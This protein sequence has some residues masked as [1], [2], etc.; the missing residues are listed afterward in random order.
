MSISEVRGR[1]V[2]D[3]EVRPW[4][5]AIVKAL[6]LGCLGHS[7]LSDL[8]GYNSAFFRALAKRIDETSAAEE[9]A[10]DKMR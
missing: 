6:S 4:R 7:R 9:N 5:K 8:R 1:F 3:G 2:A 10:L